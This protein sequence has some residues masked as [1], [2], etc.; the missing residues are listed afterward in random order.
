MIQNLKEMLLERPDSICN[1][2]QRFDFYNVTTRNNEIRFGRSPE[3][4]K[5]AISIKLLDNN[6]LNVKDYSKA[7]S[8]DFF[9]YISEEKGV[10]LKEVFQVTKNE[11]GITDWYQL[12][13]KTKRMIFGG[14]F[15]KIGKNK[16]LNNRIIDEA[17]LST[18]EAIPSRRFLNDGITLNT[19]KKFGIGY[20]IESQRITI[21]LRDQFGQLVG[22]K[23]RANWDV[24]EDEAK[25]LFL[26]KCMMSQVLYG[27]YENYS[28]MYNGDVIICEAEKS[29]MQGDSFG[30]HNIVAIGGNS[31]SATQAKMIVGMMPKRIILCLDEGLNIDVI[32]KNLNTLYTFTKM[33]DIQIGW[34]NSDYDI[35]IPE[36][37]SPTDL[38]VTKFKEILNEQIVWEG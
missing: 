20:D 23:G 6:W 26:H 5:G 2:L 8:L 28:Y 29:S 33:F 13:T 30:Y 14:F 3:S 16:I 7:I 17:V 18:Y 38:G 35:D 9:S 22:V 12:E 1:I 21:P 19:Q 37:S 34:W 24:S 15:N 36:K 31:I 25:Y 4:N 32:Q 10:E 27:Y 11:L